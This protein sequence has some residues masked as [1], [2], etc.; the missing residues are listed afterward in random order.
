MVPLG[1]AAPSRY[2][3]LHFG[4]FVQPPLG[5]TSRAE[6]EWSGKIRILPS[7][8]NTRNLLTFRRF[9]LSLV[10]VQQSHSHRGSGTAPHLHHL[11]GL[12]CTSF[13]QPRQA[14]MPP[15]HPV[16]LLLLGFF[17][18]IVRWLNSKSNEMK[19]SK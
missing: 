15:E 13:K 6:G 14:G 17:L 3:K 19:L 18:C 11:A 9:S 8:S 2:W 12:E 10:G 16:P 4:L 7:V 1:P 5:K